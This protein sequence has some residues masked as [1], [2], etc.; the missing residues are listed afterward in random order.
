MLK[1]DVGKKYK[2]KVWVRWM[3]CVNWK[4]KGWRPSR[5]YYW[6]IRVQKVISFIY[7]FNFYQL[8]MFYTPVYPDTDLVRESESRQRSSDCWCGF[9]M[10]N[11]LQNCC[12]ECVL[13]ECDLQQAI[14]SLGLASASGFDSHMTI[15]WVSYD[16]GLL[17]NLWTKKGAL[18]LYQFS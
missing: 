10:Q 2:R 14:G 15:W 11:V 18:S 12:S 8:T 7:S 9:G 1:Y 16:L 4:E 13:Q 5:A 6:A 17:D 3:R